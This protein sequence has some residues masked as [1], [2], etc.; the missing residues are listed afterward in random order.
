MF[1]DKTLNLQGI[2]FREFILFK[3]Y[4]QKNMS[5]TWTIISIYYKNL[6]K[7]ISKIQLNKKF[8]LGQKDTQSFFKV[9]PLAH[10]ISFAPYIVNL[11]CSFLSLIIF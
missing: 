1:K 6:Q 7:K 2:N 11:T 4:K 9:T 8:I 10:L 5:R 3:N